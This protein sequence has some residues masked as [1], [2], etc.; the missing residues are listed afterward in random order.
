MIDK[1]YIILSL[2][3]ITKKSVRVKQTTLV[4]VIFHLINEININ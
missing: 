2:L 3:T 4:E 1:I